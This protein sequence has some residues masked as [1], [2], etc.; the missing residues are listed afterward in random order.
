MKLY[1][2]KQ[3]RYFCGFLLLFL[4]LFFFSGIRLMILQGNILQNQFL[5]HDN[6]VVSSLLEQGVSKQVIALAITNTSSSRE[7]M[8]LLSN[9]GVTENTSIRLLPFVTEFQRVSG[10]SMLLVGGFLSVLLLGGTFLYLW[11]REALY[12]QATKVISCYT[13]GDFSC[14][15]PEWKEGTIYRLFSSIDQLSMMLQAK[16]E[17]VNKAKEFLKNTIADISHQLKTPITALSIYNEIIAGEPDNIE[18][19]KEYSKKSGFSLRRL[20]QLTHSLLKITRLDAGSISFERES[21][22]VSE[23]ISRAIGE[24]TARAKEEGKEIL[25]EESP[26]ETIVC[27]LQWTSE[28]IGN[29]VKNALDHTEAGGEVRISWKRTPAMIRILI[30][31]NGAGILPEDLHHIFKRFYR[32]KKSLDKQGAGLGLA[33][34]KAIL[35]GQGGIISVQSKLG[36]GTVFTISFL[37]EM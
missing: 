5:L 35:E 21:Y 34:S 17:S 8:E 6:A 23:V 19:V 33:L 11:K 32:S 37:T 31:D 27:D 2:D 3:T 20:E 30:A 16:N 18:I 12:L 29:I 15:M 1:L 24:L 26:E 13:E 36:E 25:V 28:A 14:H 10:Y 22:F 4:F 9:I 7:G